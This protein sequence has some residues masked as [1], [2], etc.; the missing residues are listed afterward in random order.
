[1]GRDPGDQPKDL[2]DLLPDWVGY[3]ALYFVSVLPAIIAGTVVLVLF[4]NSLR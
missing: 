3:G 4:L 2:A 1:M